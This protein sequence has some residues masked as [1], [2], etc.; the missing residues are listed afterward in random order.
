M[1]LV[2]KYKTKKIELILL[3]GSSV[4]GKLTNIFNDV[5]EL[6]TENGSSYIFKTAL[7]EFIP[8]E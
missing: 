4:S 3:D 1:D 5:L 2:N 8:L 6:E 7:K